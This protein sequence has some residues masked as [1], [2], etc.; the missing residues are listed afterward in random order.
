MYQFKE[1][2]EIENDNSINIIQQIYETI[3]K[4]F[5]NFG[6]IIEYAILYSMYY[7]NLE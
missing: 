5:E 7:E 4:M 1:Y 6:E 3:N 2:E